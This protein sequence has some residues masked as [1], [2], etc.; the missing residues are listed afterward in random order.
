MKDMNSK[1][2]EMNLDEI[3]RT[4]SDKLVH[5]IPIT[6]DGKLYVLN[7]DDILYISILNKGTRVWITGQA[8]QRLE[9]PDTKVERAGINSSVKLGEYYEQLKESGFLYGGKSYIINVNH[10][11]ARIKDQIQL[12]NG[13]E[14]S[15]SRSRKAEFD[16]GFARYWGVHY[17]RNRRDQGD[18]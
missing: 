18:I 13:Q 5:R 17:R 1:D 14:L 4:L 8:A 3:L 7:Q 16:K 12:S 15:I 6:G 9:I 2:L 11:V 10:I